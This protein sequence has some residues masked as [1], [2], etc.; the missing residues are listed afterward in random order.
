[1]LFGL[2]F[3][4]RQFRKQYGPWTFPTAHN[5]NFKQHKANSCERKNNRTAYVSVKQNHHVHGFCIR[6]LSPEFSKHS[7]LYVS[8]C[9]ALFILFTGASQFSHK[10]DHSSPKL[11]AIYCQFL[12]LYSRACAHR[13]LQTHELMRITLDVSVL[14]F[15]PVTHR[16]AARGARGAGAAGV[17]RGE[18][19]RR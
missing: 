7:V 15:A 6:T 16:L 2:F 4:S 17:P 10:C 1:M 3:Y 12:A 11:P 18:A 19:V 13:C 14:T 8:N 5:R 9:F